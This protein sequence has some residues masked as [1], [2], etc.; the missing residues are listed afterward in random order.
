MPRARRY[1]ASARTPPE[2]LHSQ[3]ST[4]RK[5]QR[6]CTHLSNACDPFYTSNLLRVIG[7]TEAG[8][9]DGFPIFLRPECLQ[10]SLP[11]PEQPDFQGILVNSINLLKFL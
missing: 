4:Q 3:K 11:G 1:R 9:R 5:A 10:H 2:P 6:A 8:F 7:P